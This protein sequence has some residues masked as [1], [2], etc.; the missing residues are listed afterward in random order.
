MPTATDMALA[1]IM[2]SVATATAMATGMAL[3]EVLPLIMTTGVVRE[4]VTELVT[5]TAMGVNREA[6]TELVRDMPMVLVTV[7]TGERS[8]ARNSQGCDLRA[9]HTI[10][11]YD[12]VCESL[13]KGK[14]RNI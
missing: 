13:A 9:L 6:A 12:G 1:A 7:D 4:V 3:V 2:A 10:I 8:S 14:H 11:F 5:E